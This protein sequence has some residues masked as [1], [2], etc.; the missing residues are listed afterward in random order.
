MNTLNPQDNPELY[1]TASFGKY[2]DDFWTS[3]LG[4]YLLQRTLEEYNSA[5]EEFRTCDPN[6]TKQ[7]SR[8]QSKMLRAESFRNWL[9][10]AIEEGA[11]ALRIIEGNDN[12]P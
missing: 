4:Q 11:K 5:L 12:E 9:S 3:D 2:V 8:I 1:H 10:E 7:V 6:D